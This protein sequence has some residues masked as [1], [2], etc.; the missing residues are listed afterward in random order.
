MANFK[1]TSEIDTASSRNAYVPTGALMMKASAA[2]LLTSYATDASC[3]S[4]GYVPCDGRILNASTFPEYQALYNV[5][6]N[7]YGGTNN[8]NFA[9]PDLRLAK[10]YIYGSNSGTPSLSANTV[11]AV[12]HNHSVSGINTQTLLTNST[13][14]THTH[15]VSY[16]MGNQSDGHGHYAVGQIPGITT[17]GPFTGALTKADGTGTAAGA[18]HTHSHGY[19]TYAYNTS[20]PIANANH[21]HTGSGT[22]A[23]YT[24]PTH[25]HTLPTTSPSFTSSAV[26]IPNINMLYFIKI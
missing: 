3:I 16:D 25:S 12:T 8:T 14:G 10:R 19:Y 15:S 6:G 9:V 7:I 1:T 5:I 17:G 23:S 11:N 2:S 22:S 18:S 4:A 20:G 26:D 21:D 24:E 13:A